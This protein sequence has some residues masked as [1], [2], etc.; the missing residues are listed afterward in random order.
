MVT[1]VDKFRKTE[2][3]LESDSFV[4]GPPLT[5]DLLA[6]SYLR[7]KESDVLAKL[8][9]QGVPDIMWFLRELSNM[10]TVGCY[11]RIFDVDGEHPQLVGFGFISKAEPMEKG[12]TKAEVNFAF[13][14][15]L[16]NAFEKVSLGV[17]MLR[18]VFNEYGYDA[19]FGTTPAKN[20]AAVKYAKLLGFTIH[21]PVKD[22][23][24]WQGEL[25]PVFISQLS[26]RDH[27]GVG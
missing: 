25:C 9:Y 27:Y 17:A 5:D 6:F 11:R 24:T 12:Y 1:S 23:C 20:P 22:S 14:P 15:G 13:L 2:R 19:L 10:V 7:M 16:T 3:W 26:K 8:F 21:G 4:V 18:F